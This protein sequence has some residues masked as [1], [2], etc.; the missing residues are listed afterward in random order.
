MH[1]KY[2]QTIWV[3]ILDCYPTSDAKSPSLVPLSSKTSSVVTFISSSRQCKPIVCKPYNTFFNIFFTVF[4]S[5]ASFLFQIVSDSCSYWIS[6]GGSISRFLP[7]FSSMI[8]S[9][10]TTAHTCVSANCV[11]SE[12]P[13]IIRTAKPFAKTSVEMDSSCQT[14]MNSPPRP[15]KICIQTQCS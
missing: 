13:V 6:A 4:H 14:C 9:V 5:I 12:A 2:R 1:Y 7:C 3:I 8:T 11:V 10:D 15:N